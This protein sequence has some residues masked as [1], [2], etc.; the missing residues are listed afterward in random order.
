MSPSYTSSPYFK[1]DSLVI[2]VDSDTNRLGSDSPSFSS[3]SSNGTCSSENVPQVHNIH[4]ALDEVP[5]EANNPEEGSNGETHHLKQIINP[6][7]EGRCCREILKEIQNLS[8]LCQDGSALAELK[9]DLQKLS[10]K[11]KQ[12]V[13]SEN[14]ILVEVPKSTKKTKKQIKQ[15]KE[16]KTKRKE[17]AKLPLH[18]KRKN[19]DSIDVSSPVK[20]QRKVI[21]SPEQNISI[22]LEKEDNMLPNVTT[23]DE[24]EKVQQLVFSDDSQT[25]QA[26]SHAS[27]ANS[28]GKQDLLDEERQ[29]LPYAK[30]NTPHCREPSTSVILV[31]ENSPDPET[32]LN[33]ND[34]TS[35]TK[36]TLYQVSK[37]N[38]LN[39]KGWLTDSEI[40]AGQ[41]LLKKE[42]PL[43]DGLWDPAIREDLVTPA[44]SEF[45][46][47]INIG[48]HW[49]CMSTIS[50]GPGTVK[51]YDTLNNSAHSIAIRHACH[52]LM[53]TGDS[54]L[55]VNERV[56]Q[57]IN[58]SDCWLFSL[59]IATDSCNAIDPS[60]QSYDQGSLRQ[61]YVHCLESG[62]MTPFP[63]TTK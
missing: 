54:V 13:P 25:I 59:A 9:N 22:V 55:F 1:I 42:F 56:Q 18:L 38:I 36:V 23:G 62:R 49:I 43:I 39:K 27:I 19:N 12:H 61:H 31:D 26:H 2:P 4:P 17:Y 50:S 7:Q 60:S 33:I 32:W 63:K 15:T 57:Q 46:Q 5:D 37:N 3:T 11:F 48:S 41:V 53:H 47:I 40:H 6:Q 58:L 29:F 21:T 51:I 24:E 45:V 34:Y 16:Q 14:G 20:K 28:E 8:Y 44:I 35:C 52:M 30:L 10:T